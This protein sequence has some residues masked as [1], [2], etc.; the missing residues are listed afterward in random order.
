MLESLRSY[1]LLPEVG[2]SVSG[3]NMTGDNVLFITFTLIT[4]CCIIEIAERIKL[5]YSHKRR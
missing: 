4:L 2:P 3:N 1:S 5:K